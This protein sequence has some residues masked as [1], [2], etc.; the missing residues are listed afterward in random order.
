MSLQHE[1]LHLDFK[2]GDELRDRRKCAATLRQYASGFANTDGGILVIGVSDG[3]VENGTPRSVTQ[4]SRPGGRPLHEWARNVLTEL[5][6]YLQ[7]PPRIQ[8]V[9]I[10]GADVLVV[11]TSRSANLTPCV[12]SGQLAYYFRI[13]DAMPRVPDCLVADFLLGRR[14]H[15]LISVQS[16]RVATRPFEGQGMQLVFAFDLANEGLV[17]ALDVWELSPGGLRLRPQ[18]QHP[19]ALGRR[20]PSPLRP[21]SAGFSTSDPRKG[22]ERAATCFVSRAAGLVARPSTSSPLP[23]RRCRE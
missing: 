15:P 3:D 6:P 9:S 11:A 16:A 23:P 7:P 8:T 12:Q 4:T 19:N 20:S 10:E 17:P 21:S 5:G 22:A 14:A 13:A 18:E 1:G 2:H